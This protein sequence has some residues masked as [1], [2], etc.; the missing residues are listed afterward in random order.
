MNLSDEHTRDLARI[1]QNL[2]AVGYEM[3]SKCE[4]EEQR[5]EV[6]ALIEEVRKNTKQVG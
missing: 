6:L 3:L 2:L 4:T 1:D 5:K